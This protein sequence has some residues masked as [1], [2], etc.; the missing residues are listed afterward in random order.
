MPATPVSPVSPVVVSLPIADRPTSHRFYR[1]GF[2]FEP[3]GEPADDGVPEPLQ[4]ALNDGLRLMLVPSGG[5]GW[6]IGGRGVAQ[7]GHSECLLSVGA[8]NE[9]EVDAM[10]ERA[11]QAGATVVTRPGQQPWGYAGVI[12]DPDGH[13]WMVTSEALPG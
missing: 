11:C 2:G 6:V 3:V 13:L 9:A 10:V 5:F 7:A 1:D 12:A 8:Q 4:F